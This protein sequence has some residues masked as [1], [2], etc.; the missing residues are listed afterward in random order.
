ML[1]GKDKSGPVCNNTENLAQ[2]APIDS[3]Y[4]SKSKIAFGREPMGEN[5]RQNLYV[6]SSQSPFALSM[7]CVYH[8]FA[9]PVRV[10]GN[11]F[12]LKVSCVMPEM[13]RHEHI[14]SKSSR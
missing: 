13:L 7:A 2:V 1:S 8:C 9:F 14:S 12:H 4:C 5:S 6:S 3:L 10:K 11:N